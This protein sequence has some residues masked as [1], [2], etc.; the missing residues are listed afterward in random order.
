MEFEIEMEMEREREK[1]SLLLKFSPKAE[2]K[3]MLIVEGRK[4]EM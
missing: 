4:L 3:T 1:G 2:E